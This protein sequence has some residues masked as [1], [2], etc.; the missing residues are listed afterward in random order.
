MCADGL[1]EEQKEL[2]ALSIGK[3]R[4]TLLLQR[5]HTPTAKRDWLRGTRRK[6]H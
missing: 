4:A 3:L 1:R 2:E 6:K 5:G